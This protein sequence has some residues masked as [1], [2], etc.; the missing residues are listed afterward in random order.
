MLLTTNLL[1]DRIN[2]TL[3]Q[4]I[5]ASIRVFYSH[6]EIQYHYDVLVICGLFWKYF[7]VYSI[8]QGFLCM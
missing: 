7:I 6:D 3:N 8:E 5:Q 1:T 4:H 2:T